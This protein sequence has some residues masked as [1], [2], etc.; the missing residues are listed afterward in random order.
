M[1]TVAKVLNFAS[2][3]VHPSHQCFASPIKLHKS[4]T[5]PT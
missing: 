1:D 3:P 5:W 4:P 2:H